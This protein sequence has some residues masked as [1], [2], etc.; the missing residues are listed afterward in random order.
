M[1]VGTLVLA[2]GIVFTILGARHR[3]SPNDAWVPVATPRI[4]LGAS[5]SGAYLAAE[6]N[7]L[8]LHF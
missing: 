3:A 2:T 4:A 6:G 7:G 1:T 5:G 8:A